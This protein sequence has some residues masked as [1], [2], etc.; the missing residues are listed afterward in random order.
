MLDGRKEWKIESSAGLYALM[1][2]GYQRD[3]NFQY[4]NIL[5]GAKGQPE[6]VDPEGRKSRP[7]I[8]LYPD[9]NGKFIRLSQYKCVL[10]SRLNYDPSTGVISPA[11]ISIDCQDFAEQLVLKFEFHPDATTVVLSEA[12]FEVSNASPK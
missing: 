2:L 5:F 4:F 10:H 8:S 12:A 7:H 3:Q 6:T 9:G 11:T 1:S